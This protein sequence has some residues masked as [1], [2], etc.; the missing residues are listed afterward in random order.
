MSGTVGMRVI[1]DTSLLV[2]QVSGD[3]K[4]GARLVRPWEPERHVVC[5]VR[6]SR[7][8]GGLLN[9]KMRP[10]VVHSVM[11]HERR[12]RELAVRQIEKGNL[13]PIV[14]LATDLG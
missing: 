7:A 8:A 1:F 13:R 3:I 14:D 12:I 9:R 6:D 2:D 10:G 5:I 4:F 11:R